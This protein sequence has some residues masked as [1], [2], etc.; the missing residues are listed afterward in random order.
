[1][2]KK[3]SLLLVVILLTASL[4]AS[5]AS[6]APT[7]AELR[8]K[9]PG[10]FVSDNILMPNPAK[11][12]QMKNLYSGNCCFLPAISLNAKAPLLMF[13]A[14]AGSGNVA[15]YLQVTTDYAIY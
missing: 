8:K 11:A 7:A 3:L 12:S 14:Y 1:M 15:N 10:Y 2:K 4:P 13:V 6:N 5:A 9:Y